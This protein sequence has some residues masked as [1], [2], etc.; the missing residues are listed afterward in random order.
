MR[1]SVLLFWKKAPDGVHLIGLTYALSLILTRPPHS[2]F[3]GKS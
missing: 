1:D 2:V 3:V